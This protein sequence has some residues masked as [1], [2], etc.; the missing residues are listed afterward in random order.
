MVMR[1]VSTVWLTPAMHGWSWGVSTVWLILVMHGWSGEE[2]QQSGLY[3]SCMDGQDRIVDSLAYTC[4]AW[5]VRR[6]VS[7]VWLILVMHGW[8]GEECRQ[9]GLYWSYMGGQERSV[10]SLAYTCHAW[11]FR[12]GVSTVWL[13]PVMHGWSGEECW[14]P[15][16]Y[17]SCMDG[18]EDT[19]C[20]VII[21]MWNCLRNYMSQVGWWM[22]KS[23]CID[24]NKSCDQQQLDLSHMD[25]L[26]KIQ[27]LLFCSVCMHPASLLTWNSMH[28]K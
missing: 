15:G 2:C 9:S 14:Q 8:S 1:G 4:H 19:L 25:L 21:G 17:L 18:Q 27:V 3:L 11:M 23:H 16:L 12:R 22:G 13:T 24:N 28:E 20:D 10:D 6:G 7:T 26:H 5:M